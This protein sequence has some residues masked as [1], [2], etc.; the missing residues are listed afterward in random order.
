MTWKLL[1]LRTLV[2]AP[3]VFRHAISRHSRSRQMLIDSQPIG[4][5]D[6]YI[7]VIVVPQALTEHVG[8]VEIMVGLKFGRKPIIRSIQVSTSKL[9]RKVIELMMIVGMTYPSL[10]RNI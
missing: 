6:P 2:V 9:E 4:V 8:A 5:F 7:I 3:L 1:A 10:S